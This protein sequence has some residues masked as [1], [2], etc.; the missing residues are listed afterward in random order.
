MP[1]SRPVPPPPT[2]AISAAAWAS[3]IAWV[4]LSWPV[5]WPN[6]RRDSTS[7]CGSSGDELSVSS[8]FEA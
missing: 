2:P 1:P 7:S 8:G 5:A 4:G 3:W 6:S